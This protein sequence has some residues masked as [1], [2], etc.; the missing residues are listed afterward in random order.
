ML[1]GGIE[2]GDQHIHVQQGPY[3]DA[4]LV[5]QPLDRRFAVDIQRGAHGDR[6]PGA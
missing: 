1:V 6:A 5:P 4:E 3:S 2:Q